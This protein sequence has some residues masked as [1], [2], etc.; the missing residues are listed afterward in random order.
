MIQKITSKELQEMDARF[1]VNFVN[2]LNGFKSGNLIATQNP[3]GHPNLA[4]FSSVVHLGSNPPLLGYIQR[5]DSVSRHT[6]ENIQSTEKFTINAIHSEMITQA[7][8]T[9]AR[10]PAEVSEFSAVGLTPEYLPGFETPFVK[11]S[12][13]KM[14]LK[15]KEIIPI[16]SNN[17]LLVVGEIEA[18]F[19]PE[20]ALHDDGFINHAELNSIA[21]GG[22]DAYFKTEKLARF[23]YA[24]PDQEIQQI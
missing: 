12:S 9:S 16:S 10:Y 14:A 19:F 23:S 20:N 21:I 24:K 17:T 2:S 6:F 1:R 13:L 15:L 3:E 8:Q 18:V 11:E 5:P 22:L 7:H 4:I